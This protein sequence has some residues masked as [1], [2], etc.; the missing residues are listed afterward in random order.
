MM[1]LARK[2]RLFRIVDDVLGVVHTHA[3]TGLLGGIL[4]G[5][6]T[7]RDLAAS[8]PTFRPSNGLVQGGGG[9]V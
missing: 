4:T 6:F 2:V 5:V 1:V 9:Q 3:V 7:L 8:F